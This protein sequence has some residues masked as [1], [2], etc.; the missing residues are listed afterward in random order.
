MPLVPCDSLPNLGGFWRCR[1]AYSKD[2]IQQEYQTKTELK[3]V[4]FLGNP[5]KWLVDWRYADRFEGELK[6]DSSTVDF[7]TD[8]KFVFKATL[9]VDCEPMDFSEWHDKKIRNRRLVL[10]LTN[11]NEFVRVLNPFTATYTYIGTSGFE[12]L[13]RYEFTFTRARMIDNMVALDNNTITSIT[14]DCNAI[15]PAEDPT[16]KKPLIFYTTT[17]Y[18]TNAGAFDTG[19]SDGF[20]T[21]Q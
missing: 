10:E 19:F 17:E 18:Y 5:E 16:P 12:N 2:I 11:N 21:Q 14:V 3:R 20:L 9:E 7:G 1:L 15:V 13:N 8:E 6:I 4:V